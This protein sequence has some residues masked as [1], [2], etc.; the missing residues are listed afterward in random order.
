[1]KRLV[2][3]Q[4]L[5]PWGKIFLL[6]AL[7][8]LSALVTAFSGLLIGRLIFGVNLESV[9]LLLTHPDTPATIA[10]MKFYQ[11]INQFGFFIIPVAVFA[12]LI[13]PSPSNYLTLDKKPQALA[14]LIAALVIYSILPFNN[15][16]TGM[17]LNIKFPDSLHFL[18]EWMKGKE[19][20]AGQLTEVF[21]KTRSLTGLWVNLLVVALI[22]AIGEEL[23]FR[24]T[25]IN[26]LKELTGNVHV[27]VIVTSFFFAFFHFQFF[28]FLPR[29]VLG[30]LL[31]YF[32][33]ISRSIWIPIFAHF[34]NNA[35]SVIIFYLYYN[36]SIK[37]S[38]NDFG[39]TSNPVYIIGSL[40]ITLWL[41]V[42][43]YRKVGVERYGL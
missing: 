10:F 12:F 30:L 9:A 28:S 17:N 35:S 11:L 21:L 22:P 37:V 42:I 20:Q 6:S 5:S 40:L 18:E 39:A 1:M 34:I 38:M 24:A 29:F 2:Y 36:G 43:L 31:G 25:G 8:I 13:S 16:L 19:Q 26:L 32:F 23:L 3:L 27:A 15:Y 41:M 33:V 14:L 4:D 7:I